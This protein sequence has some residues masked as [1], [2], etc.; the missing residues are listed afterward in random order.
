MLYTPT[1]AMGAYTGPTAWPVP[2]ATVD[3]PRG[4]I[5]T[6]S[7]QDWRGLPGLVSHN[8]FPFLAV[9]DSAS[10]LYPN[11]VFRILAY[12]CGGKDEN[13]LL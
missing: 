9:V 11:P 1:T 5:R 13:I 10:C 8:Y 12:A 6:S 4:T 3:S 7:Q 2:W